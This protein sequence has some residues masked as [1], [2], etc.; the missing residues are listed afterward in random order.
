[1]K[2]LLAAALLLLCATA[3]DSAPLTSAQQAA[4]DAAAAK[5]LANTQVPSASVAVVVD[6][7]IAYCK[8]Y[9]DQRM[10]GSAPLAAARYPIA[11]IS[12]QFTAAALLLLESD[13]KLSLSDKVDK[14]LPTLTDAANITIAQLLSHTSG[15]RDFWPQDYD[16]AAMKQ[17]VS[18]E[19]ILDRWARVPLDYAPGSQWQYSKYRLYRGRPNRR[20][21]RR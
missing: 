16:F 4:I 18:A 19:G 11:S 13:G 12:K 15:Y 21:G 8:A 7:K 3:V 9:G 14:Y 10:D 6:G 5:V 20:A 1:M 2:P 17:S